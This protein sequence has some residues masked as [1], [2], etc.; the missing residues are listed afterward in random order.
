MKYFGKNKLN[1]FPYSSEEKRI[2]E[3]HKDIR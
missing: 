3:R 2:I 1:Q